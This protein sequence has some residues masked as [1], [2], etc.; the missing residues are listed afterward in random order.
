MRSILLTCRL[1][2]GLENRDVDESGFYGHSLLDRVLIVNSG[3]PIS[4]RGDIGYIPWSF[5]HDHRVTPNFDLWL[6][7]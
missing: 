6:T 3:R 5:S 7:M 1:E 4:K 2:M